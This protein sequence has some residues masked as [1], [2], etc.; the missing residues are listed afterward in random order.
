MEEEYDKLVTPDTKR[1]YSQVSGK[2]L[3][4]SIVRFYRIKY[5]VTLFVL[6]A[7]VLGLLITQQPIFLLALIV[8]LPFLLI[9]IVFDYFA[10]VSPYKSKV[11]L[12]QKIR[13]DDSALVL[14]DETERSIPYENIKS[15]SFLVYSNQV[16]IP[17]FIK[18]LEN[19]MT[20]FK[21]VTHS[22]DTYYIPATF[23]NRDELIKEIISR[24]NLSKIAPTT[25]SNLKKGFGWHMGE[26]A[27]N[28]WERSDLAITSAN[29]N[30]DVS[31]QGSRII[32]VLYVLMFVVA[33]LALA[34]VIIDDTF[35]QYKPET[36][37]ELK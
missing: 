1:V 10:Y 28:T 2:E 18:S 23:I 30:T 12:T 22:G 37:V 8:G 36:F 14:M 7:L 27:Y 35:L 17:L 16:G 20:A 4:S 34:W 9:G 24:A 26:G 31:S 21:L 19:D 3:R 32:G 29:V 15:L 5:A 11:D 6:S 13:V 25:V 33:I